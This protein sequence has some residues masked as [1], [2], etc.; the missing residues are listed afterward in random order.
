[1]RSLQNQLDKMYSTDIILIDL[2]L[3][4]VDI[5]SIQTT[6]RDRI[7]QT[8]Q[9]TVNRVGNQLSDK[10][11]N[12]GRNSACSVDYG[13]E[14]VLHSL[15]K[16]YGGDAK[17]EIKGPWMKHRIPEGKRLS[18]KWMTGVKGFIVCGADQR[19]NTKHRKEDVKSAVEKLKAKQLQAIL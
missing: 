7:S 13:Q 9:G 11:N 12:A 4:A 8:S 15:R 18:P 2:L 19:T 17:R 3:T 10:S 5:I 14:E 16:S 1:M 6:L